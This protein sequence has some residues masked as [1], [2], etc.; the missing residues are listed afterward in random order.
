M[1]RG[2]AMEPGL[3]LA[4]LAYDADDLSGADLAAALAEAQL[5]AVHEALGAGG[6]G[7]GAAPSPA[8]ATPCHGPPIV[9]ERHL[10]AALAAARPSLAAP[11][12]ARLEGI[13][14]RFQAG[15]EGAALEPT[16]SAADKGKLKVTWA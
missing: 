5:A 11:E 10:A 15:R 13:Y 2:L 12:R 7:D 9:Q 1:S 4:R 6:D 3:D 16:P 14:R 8:G